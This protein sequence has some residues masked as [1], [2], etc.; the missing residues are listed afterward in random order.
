MVPVY[1]DFRS[2][3]SYEKGCLGW[4]VWRGGLD[5]DVD[6]TVMAKKIINT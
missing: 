4:F 1:V 2:F 3:A 5:M 6:E